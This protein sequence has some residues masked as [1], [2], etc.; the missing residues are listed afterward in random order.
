MEI[1]KFIHIVNMESLS[2]V[3]VLCRLALTMLELDADFKLD[4][5]DYMLDIVKMLDSNIIDTILYNKPTND[6]T[7]AIDVL[8][9]KLKVWM[10]WVFLL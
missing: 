9:Q 2:I 6:T 7:S 1:R 10:H 5:A 4:T 8:Y 3:D